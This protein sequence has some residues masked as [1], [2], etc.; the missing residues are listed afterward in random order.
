MLGNV[1]CTHIG[2]QNSNDDHSRGYVPARNANYCVCHSEE[3]TVHR[4]ELFFVCLQ[5]EWQGVYNT[6]R[7]NGVWMRLINLLYGQDRHGA[8]IAT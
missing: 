4:G 6:V 3:G 1:W 8:L 2:I 5:R 7:V